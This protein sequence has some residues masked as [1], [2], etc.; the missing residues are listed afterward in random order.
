MS[1]LWPHTARRSTHLLQEFNHHPPYARASIPRSFLTPHEL[2]VRPA[3]AFSEW[4]R[5]RWVS[6]SG[7]NPGRQ[8][9]TTQGYKSCYHS[10]TLDTRWVSHSGSN[11]RR[12]TATT[13]GYKSCYH[14]MKKSQFR[15]W[16][17]W[18]V[19]QHLLYLSQYIFPLH[20]IFFIHCYLET[21][22]H[23]GHIASRVFGCIL[24][25]CVFLLLCVVNAQLLSS[26]N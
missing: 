24:E 9:S 23:L 20:W 10:M 8:T 13:Q 19:A 26:L 11:P 16:I 12:Q 25:G 7:Y 6:H 15:R 3:L 18:K 5:R 14:S 21:L 1:G 17:C 4:Q 22:Q 2:P